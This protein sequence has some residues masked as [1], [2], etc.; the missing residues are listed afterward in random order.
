MLCGLLKQVTQVSYL[1]DF[2]FS[3]L[4][5]PFVWL[6]VQSDVKDKI[7]QTLPE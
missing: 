3:H 5:M 4:V 6:P 7:Y 2:I 1:L